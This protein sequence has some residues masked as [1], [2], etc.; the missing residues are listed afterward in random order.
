MTEEERITDSHAFK[1]CE[2]FKVRSATYLFKYKAVVRYSHK[3]Y[4]LIRRIVS[5]A[6]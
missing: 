1:I 6:R 5:I 4:N 3:K 2:S